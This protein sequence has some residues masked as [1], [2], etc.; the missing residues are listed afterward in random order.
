MISINQVFDSELRKQK[1]EEKKRIKEEKYYLASQ[2]QLMGRKLLKH[3]LAV[4]SMIVLA[5]MYLGV[6]FAGFIA[7]QGLE[8]FSAT[9][10][11]AEPSKLHFVHEGEFI[12][13]FVYGSK[14]AY[15]EYE[16]KYFEE[17]TSKP[18]K[19]DFFVK[20]VEYKILGFIKSD[21]HL[22]GVDNSDL[23][24]GQD[25]VA[26]FLFGADQ[27]GRD[28][29]S[30]ILLGSQVSLTVPLVGTMISFVLAL[31]I[32][33]ISGYYGGKIDTVIQRIIEVL[34]SFPTL[35]LWMALSAAIPAGLP[36][37]QVYFMITIIMSLV[38]WPWLART[39][40]SKFLSLKN[41]DYV[42]AATLFGVSDFKIIVRHLIPGFMSYLIVQLTLNI[43]TMILGE[44]SMSFLGLGMRAPATSWGVLLQEC[45]SIPNIANHPWK[46]IPVLFVIVTVL[47]FNFLGDGLRDSADPYK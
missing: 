12:G 35:P 23:E 16:M 29:F 33:G 40:R 13:P 27:L 7:P 20:G 22:F 19:I 8:D 46:L 36:I 1:K 45:Q 44:T 47:A 25:P 26:L 24:E 30:R 21:V 2:W 6:I 9:Y 31:V 32:G 17:D 5:I 39:V 38:S 4:M 42:L 3:K 41:D 28:L 10:S 37:S 14:I 34:I 43:P 11:N 18:Y 15:D